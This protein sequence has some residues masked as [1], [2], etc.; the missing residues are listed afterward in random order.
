MWRVPRESW[1][2]HEEHGSILPLDLDAEVRTWGSKA[3]LCGPHRRGAY[4]A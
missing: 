2:E 3:D 4:H 1:G